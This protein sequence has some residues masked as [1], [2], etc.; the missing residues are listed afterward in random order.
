MTA[1]RNGNVITVNG[2][3]RENERQTTGEKLVGLEVGRMCEP[4]WNGVDDGGTLRAG[5]LG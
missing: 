4:C 2:A 3:G 1:N 5:A